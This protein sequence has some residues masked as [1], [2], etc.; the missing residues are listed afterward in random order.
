MNNDSLSNNYID[1]PMPMDTFNSHNM[2]KQESSNHHNNHFMD[3]QS[4]Q[5]DLDNDS[6]EYLPN[7]LDDTNIQG[8]IILNIFLTFPFV[9]LYLIIQ[10][11]P[12]YKHFLLKLILLQHKLII[13]HFFH[14][15]VNVYTTHLPDV[16]T[17]LPTII[18]QEGPSINTTS[19]NNSSTSATAKLSMPSPEPTSYTLFGDD[20]MTHSFSDEG[21]SSDDRSDVEIDI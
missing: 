2:T 8:K 1:L 16:S 18:M 3:V 12:S 21:C 17:T 5:L 20:M 4:E 15:V 19:S 6:I 14:T 11:F 10:P 7:D 9:L 13:Y